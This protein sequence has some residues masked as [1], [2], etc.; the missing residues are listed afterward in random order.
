MTLIDCSSANSCKETTLALN[1]AIELLGGK[2][3]ILILQKLSFGNMRFK[4]LQEMVAGISP[5]VLSGELRELEQHQFVTRTVNSTKPVTVSYA[6]T[7]HA[8]EARPVIN[9]LLEFGAKHRSKI[10]G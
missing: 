8:E 5:K 7:Q 10:K 2:W 6:L 9:A 4:D 3:K 1:D